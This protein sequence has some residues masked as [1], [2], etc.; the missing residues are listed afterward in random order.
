MSLKSP[1]PQRVKPTVVQVAGSCFLSSWITGLWLRV[2]SRFN[3]IN[4]VLFSSAVPLWYKDLAIY[5]VW[6]CDLTHWGL[7][8]H[9]CIIKLCAIILILAL[10]MACHLFGAESEPKVLNPCWI[11]VI[12]ATNFNEIWIKTQK[13]SVEN[14]HCKM[15]YVKFQPFCSG[16]KELTHWGRD[17]MAGILQTF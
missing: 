11:T 2:M 17:K 14:M 9:T 12:W 1:R 10:V 13:C 6:V 15:T 4:H 8:T 3:K 16:C 5:T 7:V